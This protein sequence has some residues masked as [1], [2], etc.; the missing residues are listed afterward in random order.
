MLLG[1]FYERG[2]VL[3]TVPSANT[4]FPSDGLSLTSQP[5]IKLS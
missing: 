4:T 2:N 3:Y 1:H 5:L